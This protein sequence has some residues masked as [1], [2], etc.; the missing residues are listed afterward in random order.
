MENFEKVKH[1]LDKA[2]DIKFTLENY[3]NDSIWS[4]FGIQ[5]LEA[6]SGDSKVDKAIETIISFLSVEY[7]K[8]SDDFKNK[9][10]KK[11]ETP[12][13]DVSDLI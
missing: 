3:S 5:N 7:V 13:A 6:G 10:P 4:K 2:I 11:E 8:L 1:C 12:I 9:F